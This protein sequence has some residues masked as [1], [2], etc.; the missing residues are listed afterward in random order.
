MVAAKEQEQL[1]TAAAKEAH[2]RSSVHRL[3]NS[4]R[5]F[6]D[7]AMLAQQ[8]TILSIQSHREAKAT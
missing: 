5:K 3:H 1:A 8:S 4:C 6:Y 7:A 2:V